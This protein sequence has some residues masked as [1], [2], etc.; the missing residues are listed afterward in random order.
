[1]VNSL[2]VGIASSVSYARFACA[3]LMRHCLVFLFLLFQFTPGA[4]WGALGGRRPLLG[5]PG[6]TP[7]VATYLFA[8]GP[9]RGLLPPFQG[10]L[11]GLNV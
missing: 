9:S 8:V 5:G 4:V 2:T 6:D 7:P 10:G 1:M 3:S 11:G